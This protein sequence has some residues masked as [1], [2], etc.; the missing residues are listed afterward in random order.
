MFAGPHSASSMTC[1]GW[2]TLRHGAQTVGT[3]SL[4]SIHRDSGDFVSLDLCSAR[5]L[6]AARRTQRMT[7]AALAA[8]ATERMTIMEL[9]GIDRGKECRNDTS[10]VTIDA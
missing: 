3:V 9:S 8:F 10:P 6:H 5:R 4:G 2:T 7:I 1:P